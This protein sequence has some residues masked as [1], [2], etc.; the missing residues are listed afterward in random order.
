MHMRK[1]NRDSRLSCNLK[2]STLKPPNSK[3]R[4]FPYLNRLERSRSAP[5]RFALWFLQDVIQRLNADSEIKD[6]DAHPVK[7]ID[8]L[9]QLISCLG[10]LM[11]CKPWRRAGS[12]LYAE[13]VKTLPHQFNSLLNKRHFFACR[14]GF[15]ALRGFFDI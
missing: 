2:S 11:Y 8:K 13:P 10:C 12:I 4:E 15:S 3:C 7:T 9:R 5:T 6:S 14:N 1:L